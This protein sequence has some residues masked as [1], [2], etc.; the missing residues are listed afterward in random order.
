MV[1][2]KYINECFFLG[3][4]SLKSGSIQCASSIKCYTCT[5]SGYFCSLPLNLAGGEEHNENDIE[6][7]HYGSDY[8]CQVKFYKIIQLIYFI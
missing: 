8:V 7:V 1:R 6:S 4:F 3:F 2:Y 5:E